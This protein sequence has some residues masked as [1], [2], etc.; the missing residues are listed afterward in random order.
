M[1]SLPKPP[2]TVLVPPSAMM[3]SAPPLPQIRS[4][5]VP[6]RDRI[7]RRR[8][9]PGRPRWC[10]RRR[11]RRSCR[12]PRCRTG[13]RCPRR[14]RGCR[15]PGRPRP[16][17]CPVRPNT[18]SLS[19]LPNS[20][21]PAAQP[22]DDVVARQARRSCRDLRCRRC[23]SLPG[24][25]VVLTTRRRRHRHAHRRGLGHAARGHRV[26]ER[27]RAGVA[28]GR[29]V[30]DEI[31]GGIAGRAVV[32]DRRRAVRG[33]ADRGDRAA[34]VLE[35]VVGEEVEIVGARI[36]RDRHVVGDDVGDRR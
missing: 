36:L 10:W 9:N 22:V 20:R 16:C 29:R 11:R 32:V 35:R 28:R 1:L 18:V 26:G 3:V 8:R 31:V 34:G 25:G 6:A 24:V 7:G 5:P 30:D 12:R 15:C 4:A 17:R 21:S 19:W 14:R 27:V 13:S 33:R 23:L 2:I